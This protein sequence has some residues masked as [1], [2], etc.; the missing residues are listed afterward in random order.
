MSLFRAHWSQFI[1]DLFFS[2]TPC[3]ILLEINPFIFFAVK[4]VNLFQFLFIF[5]HLFLDVFLFIC[6]NWNLNEIFIFFLIFAFVHKVHLYSLSSY[7]WDFKVYSIS[8]VCYWLL[9]SFSLHNYCLQKCS[10][11]LSFAGGFD[12]YLGCVFS[13]E[14]IIFNFFKLRWYG[15]TWHVLIG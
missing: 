4:I 7:I 6:G 11:S 9:Y 14:I 1:H 8:I 12:W 10:F 2:F 13:S 15:T 3:I 5:I